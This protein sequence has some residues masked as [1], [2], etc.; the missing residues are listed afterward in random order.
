MN[1]KT[2]IKKLQTALKQ[3]G[4]IV[5]INTR[6]FYSK[7]QDRFITMYDVLH[8]TEEK[9]RNGETVIRDKKIIDS[10]ASQIDIVKALA[11]KHKELTGGK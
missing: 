10:T 4:Y 8:P 5:K 6:Q 7:D 11:K 2:V 9:N 3:Q 1:T